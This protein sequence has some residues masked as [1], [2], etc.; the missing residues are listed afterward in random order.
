V[1][2]ITS[3]I[4]FNGNKRSAWRF[5]YRRIKANPIADPTADPGDMHAIDKEVLIEDDKKSAYPV[6][7]VLNPARLE[8]FSTEFDT[9]PSSGR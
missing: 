4:C 3:F 8:I 5:R 7:Q 9:I 1:S 2:W 6:S